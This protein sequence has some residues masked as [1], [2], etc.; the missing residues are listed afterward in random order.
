MNSLGDMIGIYVGNE[1]LL[2]L[3]QQGHW[4]P[5]IRQ[6]ISGLISS[7]F[8]ILRGQDTYFQLNI[9]GQ[10]RVSGRKRGRRECCGTRG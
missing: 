7:Y 10:E 4:L 2:W 9:S 8:G 5:D 6:V 1:H 3:Y